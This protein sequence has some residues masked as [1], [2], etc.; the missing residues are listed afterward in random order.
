MF[1][2][3]HNYNETSHQFSHRLQLLTVVIYIYCCDLG[4]ELVKLDPNYKR[5]GNGVLKVGLEP[6]Y[7]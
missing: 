1:L 2:Y 5:S 6:V 4:L 3:E 7:L